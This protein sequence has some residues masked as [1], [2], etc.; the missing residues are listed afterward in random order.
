MIS[1]VMAQQ[2]GNWQGA[3]ESVRRVATARGRARDGRFSIEGIRLHERAIRAGMPLDQVLVAESLWHGGSPRIQQ[4]L[5]ELQTAVSSLITIPDPVMTE[6]TEGRDLGGLLG[7]IPLPTAPDLSQ[8]LA[9]TT[10]PLLLVAVEVV[11]PGN[12][13]ALLRLRYHCFRNSRT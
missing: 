2:K 5:A 4:L 1:A 7:L 8:L 11:D 6:L 10:T 3:V 9:A 13:G 12:V